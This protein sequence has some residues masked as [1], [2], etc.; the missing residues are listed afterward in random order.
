MSEI[1][2]LSAFP[3][4]QQ[5]RHIANK[6]LFCLLSVLHSQQVITIRT[7]FIKP[8]SL[9]LSIFYF[10]EHH[11]N[12]LY[13]GLEP[14]QRLSLHQ[15]FSHFALHGYLPFYQPHREFSRISFILRSFPLA[16]LFASKIKVSFDHNRLNSCL[17]TISLSSPVDFS[18]KSC[19][20]VVALASENVHFNQ[21][22]RKR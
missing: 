20:V 6:F 7:C 1:K 8:T 3:T 2:P 21:C 4:L 11:R 10:I 17:I 5:S 18:L 9:K 14:P 15:H 16:K 13:G 19:V 22:Y 12:I